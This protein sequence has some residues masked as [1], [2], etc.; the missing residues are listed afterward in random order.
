MFLNKCRPPCQ[1]YSPKRQKA[2]TAEEHT[3]FLWGDL[4]KKQLERTRRR[5]EENIKIDL[6]EVGW[7]HGLD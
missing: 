5:W 2:E 6:Q 7:E 3:E 1:V 4:R